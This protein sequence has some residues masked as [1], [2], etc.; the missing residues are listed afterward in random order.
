MAFT[1]STVGPS[2]WRGWAL[3]GCLLI[4][5]AF[6]SAADDTGKALPDV[7]AETAPALARDGLTGSAETGGAVITSGQDNSGVSSAADGPSIEMITGGN[8]A[9][10]AARVGRLPVLD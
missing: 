3:A 6:A 10:G 5:P 7:A 1:F 2:P 9:D 4:G 8:S